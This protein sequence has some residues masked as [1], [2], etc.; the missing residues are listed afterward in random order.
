MKN[1]VLPV[2]CAN[3]FILLPNEYDRRVAAV[4]ER[5][6]TLKRSGK[7]RRPLRQMPK[8][9]IDKLVNE[10]RHRLFRRSV[11]RHLQFLHYR[12]RNNEAEVVRVPFR[13]VGHALTATLTVTRRSRRQL[14]QPLVNAR[15]CNNRSVRDKYERYASNT[16][17]RID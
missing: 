9:L 2:V 4:P 8:R 7:S 16:Y 5:P 1:I 11:N 3:L 15:N 10:R 17:F 6:S 12:H 14:V 13:V